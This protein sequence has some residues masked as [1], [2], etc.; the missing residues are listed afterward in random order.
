MSAYIPLAKA[1][2]MAPWAWTRMFPQWKQRVNIS[3]QPKLKHPHSTQTSSQL[4]LE[5]C[6]NK[7]GFF[8]KY[9]TI[10]SLRAFTHA[11]PLPR[12]ISHTFLPHPSLLLARLTLAH[13]FRVLH[14]RSSFFRTQNPIFLPI[15][16][17]PTVPYAWKLPISLSSHRIIFV[18]TDC[19]LL[20]NLWAPRP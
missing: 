11:V 15:R 6:K 13:S 3:K 14:H 5:N 1:S 18:T 9:L 4:S 19:I 2:H 16:G 7:H 17:S 10:S 20:T 8:T 12:V